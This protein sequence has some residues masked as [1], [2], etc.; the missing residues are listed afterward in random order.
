MNLPPFFTVID[1]E[2]SA[3]SFLRKLFMKNQSTKKEKNHFDYLIYCVT[4][5]VIVEREKIIFF[6]A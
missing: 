6:L 1:G 2:S 5:F 3:F 4:A